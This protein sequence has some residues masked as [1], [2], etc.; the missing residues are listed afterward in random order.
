METTSFHFVTTDGVTA[1]PDNAPADA[2]RD[3][4]GH[5]GPIFRF[6]IDEEAGAIRVQDSSFA[7]KMKENDP[8]A[9][10]LVNSALEETERRFGIRFPLR[11]DGDPP[12][13]ATTRLLS[14]YG[15]AWAGINRFFREELGAS[16]PDIGVYDYVA[17]PGREHETVLFLAPGTLLGNVPSEAP[18]L[19]V[20]R[21]LA[22]ALGEGED[23]DHELI[24]D[25]LL[26]FYLEHAALLMKAIGTPEAAAAAEAIDARPGWPLMFALDLDGGTRVFRA[27]DDVG[28]ERD[29]RTR[30]PWYQ[31]PVV[32]FHYDPDE[33]EVVVRNHLLSAM[34]DD[35]AG[36]RMADDV[37]SIVSREAGRPKEEVFLSFDPCLDRPYLTRTSRIP[38]LWEA[39]AADGEARDVPILELP[40]DIPGG[41]MVVR[42]PEEED[43][44][45]RG[46]RDRNGLHVEYPFVAIDNRLGRGEKLRAIALG[47]AKIAGPPGGEEGGLELA[48]RLRD[49]GERRRA[50]R[51]M[52]RLIEMGLHPK[53]VLDL[54]SDRSSLPRRAAY[55]DVL[56]EAC[57]LAS[58]PKV[59]LAS[60]PIGIND[61][62]WPSAQE[63]L[64]IK[65]HDGGEPESLNKSKK[66]EPPVFP[67]IE[68]LL[69]RDRDERAA[70]KPMELLLRESQR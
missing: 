1:N 27:S 48:R 55:R 49:P 64:R 8:E 20:N 21:M 51:L 16:P 28:C 36:A 6:A 11:E 38:P 3:A 47:H 17:P 30:L 68:V 14:D 37:A 34:Y 24:C 35:E 31:G 2:I 9:W 15:P 59:V 42:G 61:W 32:A 46:E 29:V 39:I 26:S 22:R 50:R 52:A 41:W 60:L 67:S 53:A 7:R 44:T 62:W 45:V 57:E 33:G 65:G 54:F 5:R 23:A 63:G 69:S 19:G 12:L 43:E 4:L 18:M 58:R 56:V 66:E 13:S 25:A 70:Q 10:E 40:A